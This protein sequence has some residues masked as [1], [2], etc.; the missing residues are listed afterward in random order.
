MYGDEY[1]GDAW[2]PAEEWLKVAWFAGT[3]NAETQGILCGR[4]LWNIRIA[5]PLDGMQG[6]GYKFTGKSRRRN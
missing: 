2:L 1:T 4:R 6:M 5:G 3:A